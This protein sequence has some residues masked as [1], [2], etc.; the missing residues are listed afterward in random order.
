[1]EMFLF[2]IGHDQN[3][4][5]KEITHLKNFFNMLMECVFK[6]IENGS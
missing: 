1:M 5:K 2:K 6:R 3:Y 4:E